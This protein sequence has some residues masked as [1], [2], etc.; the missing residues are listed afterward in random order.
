M[1][2][3]EVKKGGK[4]VLKPFRF[5]S[6]DLAVIK[7]NAEVELGGNITAWV[8]LRAKSLNEKEFRKNLSEYKSEREEIW[9]R[10]LER[11]GLSAPSHKKK[12]A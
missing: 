7:A 9:Q 8:T 5:T 1:K 10:K 11:R 6:K 12:R 2:K 4:T 3:G